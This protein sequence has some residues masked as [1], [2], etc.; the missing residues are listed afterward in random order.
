MNTRHKDLYNHCIRLIDE[1]EAASFLAA[2]IQA[3]SSNP[4]GNERRVALVD[5]KKFSEYGIEAKIED[6]PQLEGEQ[7]AN[8]V[9]RMEGTS[10]RPHLLYSAHSDVVP[11]T[12]MNWEHDPFGGEIEGELMYGR[13]TVDMK[14]G[15][16]A[17]IMA[18][19]LLKKAGIEL[20]GT[21]TF[22]H[23]CSEEVCFHGSAAYVKTHG[24][25]DVDA[26]AISEP[27]NSTIYIAERGGFWLKFTS[28]GKTAHGGLPKEGINAL[29]HMLL[30]FEKFRNYDFGGVQH[31]LLG[32]STLSITTLHAGTNTN[33]IPEK[34]EATVDIR[35]VPG[36]SHEK[37]LVD[38]QGIIDTLQKANSSVRIEVEPINDHPPLE[39]DMKDPFVN[40]AFE[41]Y[42][43]VYGKTT[44]PGGGY[45]M[46]DAVSFLERKSIPMIICGPG[47]TTLIH[48]PEEHVYIP[49]YIDCIKYYIA[50]AINFCA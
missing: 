30:F 28:Y 50:L 2:M 12:R 38:I 22:A 43:Q 44:A 16:A 25:D 24:M 33:V 40:L 11:A 18:M 29:S 1:E 9:A 17:M 14:S 8:L 19:C 26:L 37:I 3:D 46:T 21:I 35:T 13:G 4:P 23:T 20:N 47:D 7:R 6:L 41:T 39:S 10:A 34:C 31:P 32:E 45:Y 49:E 5:Q 15:S 42:S 27:T 36:V 48:K